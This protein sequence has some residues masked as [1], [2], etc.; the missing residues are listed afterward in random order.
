MLAP[1]K[2]E[3]QSVNECLLTI[4][5][6]FSPYI[7]SL[8]PAACD[9]L[10]T[11]FAKL[12]TIEQLFG[13]YSYKLAAQISEIITNSI[14]YQPDGN[15]N[16]IYAII[17]RKN[18]FLSLHQMELKTIEAKLPKAITEKEK[19]MEDSPDSASTAAHLTEAE[20]ATIK[21]LLNLDTIAYLINLLQPEIEKLSQDGLIEDD[22]IIQYLKASTLIGLL[23]LPKPISV[24]KYQSNDAVNI[25]ITSFLYGTLYLH[26]SSPSVWA[27]TRVNLFHVKTLSSDTP[28][29]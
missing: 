19:T 25:W 29:K 3:N 13:N 12:T 5:L 10:V 22:I 9:K 26:A 6:N 14:Q 7:K 1:L 23:P 2:V 17:R 16:L 15:F 27:G 24:R 28:N 21:S 8:N 18:L 4:L 20:F 11:L